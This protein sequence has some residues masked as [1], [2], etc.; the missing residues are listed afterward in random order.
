MPDLP[1]GVGGGVNAIG[2]ST[3]IVILGNSFSDATFSYCKSWG[4]FLYEK[5]LFL[6]KN[7]EILC[8]GMIRVNSSQELIKLIRDVIPQQ[9][10]IVINVSGVCNIEANYKEQLVYNHPYIWNYQK[11]LFEKKLKNRKIFTG[12]GQSIKVKEIGY[13]MVNEKSYAQWWIDDMRM[14]NAICTE[15]DIAYYAILQPN[16]Y[17][18]NYQLTGLEHTKNNEEYSQNIKKWYGEVKKYME[19]IPYIYDFTN[20]FDGCEDIYWDTC[21]VYENGNR[22]MADAVYQLLKEK[23]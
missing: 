16:M 1:F 3:R 14:M 22:I 18:G 12:R 6:G 5:L 4:E 21:H 17:M 13:G 23:L 7:V 15:F 2:A 8:G 11:K 19:N 20:I 10:C 9:P